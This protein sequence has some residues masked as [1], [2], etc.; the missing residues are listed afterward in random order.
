MIA[1]VGFKHQ[2]VRSLLSPL[3]Q[4]AKDSETTQCCWEKNVKLRSRGAY[5]SMVCERVNSLS[6]MAL[7][8]WQTEWWHGFLKARRVVPCGAVRPKWLGKMT[9]RQPP[10]LFLHGCSHLL[11][12]SFPDCAPAPSLPFLGTTTW[13]LP[14]PVLSPFTMPEWSP[15]YRHMASY[16]WVSA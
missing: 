15:P 12:L 3:L 8:A 14:G 5:L 11:L 2:R 10:C 16:C 1:N 7:Q 13:F 4:D 9:P 6:L